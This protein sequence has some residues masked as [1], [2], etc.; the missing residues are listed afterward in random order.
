VGENNN[1]LFAVILSLGVLLGWQYLVVEPRIAEERA[2]QLELNEKAMPSQ[3]QLIDENGVPIPPVVSS[4]TAIPAV[5]DKDITNSARVAIRSDQFSGS[6]ALLGARFD[7]LMLEQYKVELSQTSPSVRLLEPADQASYWQATFGWV[8]AAGSPLDV[9]NEKSLWTQIGSN[10]L[11]PEQD[12][13]L[14]FRSRDG[15]VFTR[16]IAVDH[17][18][19]F[20][21]TDR[22]RQEGTTSVTLY[23]FGQISRKSRPVTS[24]LFVLHE[25]PV[26]YLGE[27][28]LQ[29][30][31]YEDLVEEPT[32]KF[33]ATGGWLGFT[34]KYWATALVPPQ[35]EAL[36]ARFSARSAQTPEEE[37]YRADYLL[38]GRTVNPGETIEAT[39]KLFAGAKVVDEI[40]IY[41][42]SGIDHFDLMIDWG[43]FYFLTKPMFA[44]LQFFY[45]LLGNYG[46]SILAVTVIVKILFFPLA[47][48]SYETMAKMKKMQ[49]KMTQIREL[50][51]DDKQQQQQEMLKIYREE[52]LNPL[53]GCL[54]VLLQIPVFFSLYKVLFVT[55]DMRHQPFFG[56]VQ[57]LA[58]PDPTS[59][60]NLFGL[61]P[62]DPPS[63]LMLGVWPLLMGITMFVQMQM[64]PPPPDPIQATVFK[65]MPIFFTFLLASFPAGLVIYWAWNNFL[66]VLQ[67][68]YIMRKN[69][70]DIELFS[71]IGLRKKVATSEAA[72]DDEKG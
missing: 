55:L 9:P 27:S 11:T 32:Y 48:R 60:F 14:E 38:A 37:V 18:F 66:S 43:W 41:A 8:A 58:A 35:D 57:D 19:M 36:D 42:D 70:V 69:G 24:N 71:N 62:W 28:G 29:E 10:D 46:L 6:V 17:K 34:D 23:P 44:A 30:L 4:S 39:G 51:K 3:D 63:I 7:D 49:P 33:K 56:W 15:L 52:K 1:F 12:I 31:S 47:S 5:T 65:Y 40:D 67:Q 50:H 20:S 13:S 61:I 2:A 26:G 64:N 53:A 16:T 59:I 21:I 68:G 22:V 25:G 72:N 54:P 45:G